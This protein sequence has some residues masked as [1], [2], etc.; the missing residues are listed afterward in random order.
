MNDGELLLRAIRANPAEDTPRLAYAD[1]IE[2][3]GDA[4]RAEFIRLQ[5]LQ[6]KSR[7]IAMLYV[8]HWK[9]WTPAVFHDQGY[10]S[11]QRGFIECVRSDCLTFYEHAAEAFRVGC[12]GRVELR[13][14]R[15]ARGYGNGELYWNRPLIWP[16]KFDTW[17]DSPHL[18]PPDLWHLLKGYRRT[19]GT[20]KQYTG[21][22][23]ANNDLAAAALAY[24]RVK[25]AEL[26]GVT[27]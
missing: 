10:C 22:A 27:V 2:E 14:R 20:V 26:E 17:N 23:S 11:Y 16:Q 13:D 1:W 25:L 15:P 3:E 24:G 9:Q 4:A 8:D 5:V 19:M 21:P 6:P 7:K 18:L 12:V